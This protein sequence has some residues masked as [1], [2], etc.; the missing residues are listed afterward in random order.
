MQFNIAVCEDNESDSILL[1]EQLDEACEKLDIAANI[2]LFCTGEDFLSACEN[3][4]YHIAF[5]DIYL[6]GITGIEAAK[7]VKEP[8]RLVFTTA[9]AEHAVQAFGL[10]ADHYLLK[11]TTAEMVTEALKRCVDAFS[12]KSAQV[13]AIKTGK[14]IMRIPMENIMY[15]EVENKVCHVYTEDCV[16]TASA[17]LNSLFEY[18]DD[19]LFMRAQKSYAVNMNFIEYFY[20]DHIIMR[21]G[22]E[23]TLS[24]NNR[25]ELKNQYQQ[26]LFGQVRSGKV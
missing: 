17:S 5:I 9:S 15:I 22:R 18:L 16:Y 10:N 14:K 2:D 20:Y 3:N 12:V 25:S 26:F 6:D 19:E 24:R 23:I 4:K 13:L 1:S 11:P 7:R 8:C 21:G